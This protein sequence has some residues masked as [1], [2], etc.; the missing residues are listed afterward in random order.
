MPET[1][2]NHSLKHF[3]IKGYY[4]TVFAD[5][6]T[7]DSLYTVYKYRDRE[8]RIQLLTSNEQPPCFS[9]QALLAKVFFLNTKRKTASKFI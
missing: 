1:R 4:L 9:K 3:E 5:Q 6:M 2:E 8:A 7:I